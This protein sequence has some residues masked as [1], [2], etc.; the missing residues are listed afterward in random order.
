MKTIVSVPLFA[1]ATAAVAAFISLAFTGLPDQTWS[2]YGGFDVSETEGQLVRNTMTT[3][4][5]GLS[6]VPYAHWNCGGGTF[7]KLTSA[8]VSIPC[9]SQRIDSCCIEHDDCY[10]DPRHNQTYCDELFCSCLDRFHTNAVCSGFSQ[11]GLCL[12]THL[13]GHLFYVAPEALSTNSTEFGGNSSSV[14]GTPSLQRI[15]E[16]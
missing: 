5:P 14:H 3:D 7:S 15:H 10:D 8:L 4:E 11:P 9:D 16:G 12:A 13:F 1:K 6:H 2:I